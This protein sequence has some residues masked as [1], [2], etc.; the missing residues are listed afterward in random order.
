M[1]NNIVHS[2]NTIDGEINN[3]KA[4]MSYDDK[5]NSYLNEIVTPAG[6]GGYAN[7]AVDR[8]GET[9][10]GI[11]TKWRDSLAEGHPL[12]NIDIPS[13]TPQ[14]AQNIYRSSEFLGPLET[15][16]GKNPVTL[17]MLDISINAGARNGTGIMQR[18]LQ[19]LGYNVTYD[20]GMGDETR[21]AYRAA[22]KE[23]GED[24]VLNALSNSQANFY[25]EI[26]DND[27]TQNTFLTGWLDRAKRYG[28]NHSY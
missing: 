10:Y 28:S 3:N 18:A 19:S 11:S 7:I 8:G 1:S 15:N 16:Y 20:K 22:M 25:R 27:N 2:T 5:L 13:L 17:K 23:R 4:I 26:V 9:K 14:D 12:R 6:E 21:D 24:A